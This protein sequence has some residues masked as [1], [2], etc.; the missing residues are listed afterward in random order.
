MFSGFGGGFVA[1]FVS[2]FVSREISRAVL[3]VA[4]PTVDKALEASSGRLQKSKESFAHMYENF[5]DM[6]AEVKN[7]AAKKV[8]KKTKVTVKEQVVSEGAS[9]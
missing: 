7:A 6:V 1:G 3:K 2:G 9:T 4:K 8:P 5:E